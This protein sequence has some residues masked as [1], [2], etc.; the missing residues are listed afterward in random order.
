MNAL[1]EAIGELCKVILPIP[2]EFYPGNPNSQ[3]CNLHACKH[4]FT[5]K[6][7]KF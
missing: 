3:N 6:F 4:R 1:G 7:E 2:E 5:K